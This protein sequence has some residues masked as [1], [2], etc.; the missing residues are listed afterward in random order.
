MSKR[1]TTNEVIEQFKKVHRD[2]YDYS[3]V[4]YKTCQEKVKIICPIHG[5]FEQTPLE[6]KQGNNCPKCVHRSYKYTTDEWIEKAKVVHGNKYDYS[7]VDYK[8]NKTKVCIICPKHGEFWQQPS[9]HLKGLGCSK[10]SGLYHYTNEEF[11]NKAKIVNND[12]YDYS[13]TN[14]INNTTKI[15]VICKEHGLFETFPGHHLQGVGCPLCNS[16]KLEEKVNYLLLKKGINVIREKKFE[17]L[18]QKRLDFYLPDY[19]IAI[20]CQGIQ[21]YKP[22]DF[23]GGEKT[24]NENV[25]RDKIKLDNCIKHNV[26]LFYINYNDNIEEKVN[27][28]CRLLL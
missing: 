21:H 26:K 25:N 16:S 28:I 2:K 4:E 23:F 6:H 5:I 3:L 20:E 15:K 27:E 12:K 19:S 18:G 24:F 10:C 14:Y 8:N 7:K 22:I 9:H 13:E 11:I 1:L 17:W